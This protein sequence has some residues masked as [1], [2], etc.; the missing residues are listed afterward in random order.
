M[1]DDGTTAQIVDLNARRAGRAAVRHADPADADDLIAL[2]SHPSE[3]LVDE[4]IQRY[5]ERIQSLIDASDHCILVAELDGRIVG[6][7][8]AQ[9]YGPALRRD[10]SVA[11]MHDLWVSPDARRRGAGRALFAA[12]RDWAEHETNIRLL[13]WQSTETGRGF[14]RALD[15]QAEESTAGPRFGLN[16]APERP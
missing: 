7:A 9:D 13:E 2:F 6:Y 12:I 11:R 4:K 3:S 8:A 15:L 10:W 16:F 14:F 1:S 5:R